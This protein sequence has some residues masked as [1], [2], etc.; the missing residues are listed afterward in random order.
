MASATDSKTILDSSGA[1]KLL[2]RGDMLFVTAESS[3]P[4]RIQGAYVSDE[5]IKV[6]VD[7]LKEKAEPE[8]NEAVIE[9]EIR[10]TPGFIGNG[11]YDDE[12]A[13]EAKEVVLKAGKAS[14]TLLQRRLKVGYARAARLLD[15]LEEM[16]VVGSSEGS[17]PR[18]V[19]IS[20]DDLE[21]NFSSS[22]DEDEGD[23]QEHEDD[24]Q[25]EGD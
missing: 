25:E 23:E 3:K 4:K 10:G 5:E 9:K 2:G 17:K 19:L 18:E 22:L 15:I 14:A 20:Q 7:F 11:D 12:L 6:V 13:L 16:G 1:E 21:D 24:D 8:Y